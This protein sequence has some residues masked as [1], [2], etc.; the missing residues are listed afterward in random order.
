[1]SSTS[2]VVRES[3]DVNHPHIEDFTSRCA[4]VAT[5]RKRKA[6]TMAETPID[7]I[8]LDGPEKKRLLKVVRDGLDS[9][10]GQKTRNQVIIVGAGAAGITAAYELLR[11]GY[12]VT[13]LEKTQ[14]AGVIGEKIFES[15]IAT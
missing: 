6:G 12:N 11:A 13:V 5:P 7:P 10:H 4:F 15:C 14:R 3:E 8:P 9:V 1:M 2:S